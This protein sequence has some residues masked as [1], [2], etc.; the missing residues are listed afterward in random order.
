MKL[1]KQRTKSKGRIR[2][3]PESTKCPEENESGW[4]S[5]EGGRGQF[6]RRRG[7][8]LVAALGRRLSREARCGK[9]RGRRVQVKQQRSPHW[10]VT[11]SLH[12]T[13]RGPQPLPP[14]TQT[15]SSSRLRLK[16]RQSHLSSLHEFPAAAE[17]RYHKPRWLNTTVTYPPAVLEA[18][19]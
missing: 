9:S 18:Y 1:E 14:S 8:A 17:T 6:R 2:L 5:A 19:V 12:G 15:S 16:S 7:Q 10:T 3:R 13:D 4:Q 11:A